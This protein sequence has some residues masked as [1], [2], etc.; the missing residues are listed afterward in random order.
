[1]GFAAVSGSDAALPAPFA[2]A[3]G[4][5]PYS[6]GV[7]FE[8]CLDTRLGA[9]GNGSVFKAI[10][11]GGTFLAIKE[12][13]A[14]DPR[15]QAAAELEVEAMRA[16][17]HPHVVAIYGCSRAPDGSLRV[18]MELCDGASLHDMRPMT[19]E[20][21][22]PLVRQLL[23]G[24][25]YVHRLGYVHRDIKGAN[26]L[27]TLRNGVEFA[28]LADMGS[29]VHVDRLPASAAD[30]VCGLTAQFAAPEVIRE[31]RLS[32]AADVWALGCML[33]EVLT[34]ADPWAE[35][36]DL[37]PIMLMQHIR[38]TN[39]APRIPEGLSATCTDLIRLC[40][41][42]DTAQRPTAE[43]L[44]L[45]PWV[46]GILPVPREG[47]PEPVHAHG[48][49]TVQLVEASGP[50]AVRMPLAAAGSAWDLAAGSA[51]PAKP[52]RL[53][54]FDRLSR[55]G[56]DVRGRTATVSE[57]SFTDASSHSEADRIRAAGGAHEGGARFKPRADPESLAAASLSLSRSELRQRYD[58]VESPFAVGSS[59]VMNDDDDDDAYFAPAMPLP[60]HADDDFVPFMPAEEDAEDGFQ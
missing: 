15:G 46:T 42:V 25:A 35:L 14:T 55:A 13:R 27:V 45:H 33:I 54:R 58:T 47:G 56:V 18:V 30:W 20:H 6:S 57:F 1:M 49:F 29:A 3:R 16:L 24:L 41:T 26:V 31:G 36:G 38:T 48:E 10:A 28:K 39:T 21:L 50:R 37:S 9:G 53:R 23:L 17:D 5:S 51:A 43:A 2:S 4:P 59:Y 34:A 44:L 22:R 60:D 7:D 32:G 52:G 11:T 12:F 19:E 8:M 40:L